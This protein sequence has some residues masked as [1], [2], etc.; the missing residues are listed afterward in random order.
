MVDKVRHASADI[1]IALFMMVGAGTGPEVDDLAGMLGDNF[2]SR[3]VGEPA[4]VLENLRS[5]EAIGISRVQV[6]EFV[7]GT[8]ENLGKELS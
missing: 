4:K 8:I 7:P 3:F 1:P 2:C 6:T 5:L